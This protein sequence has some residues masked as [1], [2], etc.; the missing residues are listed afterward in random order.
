MWEW[1]AEEGRRAYGRV[2]PSRDND[3]RQLVLIEPVGPVAAFV[4]WNGPLVTPSRGRFCTRSTRVFPSILFFQQRLLGS[5]AVT[6]YIRNTPLPPL[7][8]LNAW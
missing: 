7:C 5:E 2:I 8:R 3:A 1:A 4:T 6:H